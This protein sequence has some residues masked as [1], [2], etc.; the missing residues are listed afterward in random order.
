MA[1]K[2]VQVGAQMALTTAVQN[3]T[4]AAMATGQNM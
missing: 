1:T 3:D 4:E 2:G